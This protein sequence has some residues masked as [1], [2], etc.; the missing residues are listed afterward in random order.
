MTEKLYDCDSHLRQFSA[1]VLSCTPRGDEFDV[2]LNRTAFYPEGGGQPGDRGRLGA[3]TVTDTYEKDGDILHRC[4]APLE[5]GTEVTGE[6]DWEYRFDL[7]QQHSGEHI[8]SG[9]IHSRF[10]YDN[11]GF[12]M[13]K[14]VVTI[15]FNGVIGPEV[16]PELEKAANE[17]VWKNQEVIARY[18]TAEELQELPYRSKKAL[19]GAV[20]IVEFPGI[21]LC[22]CC[23]THVRRTGEIGLVKLLSC[24]HFREGVR[25][26]MLCGR[27]ALERLSAAMEQNRRVSGLLSAKPLETAD[28]VERMKQE[29]AECKYQAVQLENRRF[30][31]K[32]KELTKA[33]NVLLFEEGLKPDGL[34]RLADA[35]MQTCGGRCAVFSSTEEGFFYAIGQP[36][37]DLRAMTKEMNASLNGRGGGKPFFVQGSVRATEEEIRAFFENPNF[38]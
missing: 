15:D 37:G 25:I 9:I 35:V 20:R 23:G 34:R 5:P 3:V 2:V 29:L 33:G 1:V 30:E 13:G 8:V 10:G 24:Q 16:L 38:L 36:G 28:A 21:D 14:D 22:A 6:I 31:A 17:A 19:T 7:M 12:H 18:P 26:E 27:M 32:A 11:V 4:Q